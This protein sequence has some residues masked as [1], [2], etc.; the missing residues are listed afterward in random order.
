MYSFQE[1][2]EVSG[3]T[4]SIK[5][6]LALE[7]S[8]KYIDSIS[9]P[10]NCTFR[11]Q[12]G[13][14]GYDI[15]LSLIWWLTC[16]LTLVAKSWGN[17][18]FSNGQYADAGYDHQIVLP[19]FQSS[20]PI[21]TKLAASLESWWAQAS[22]PYLTNSE[23]PQSSE[24]REIQIFPQSLEKLGNYRYFDFFYLEI[25]QGNLNPWGIWQFL[26]P[27]TWIPNQ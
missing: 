12:W 2:V 18:W 26:A 19:I 10:F 9:G 11:M 13:Y 3:C 21:L 16:R 6:C 14:S 23:I 17:F 1:A 20:E 15:L 22:L 4:L 27:E 24:T 8:A 5:Y 7:S 25:S